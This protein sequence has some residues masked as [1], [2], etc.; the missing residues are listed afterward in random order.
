[1]SDDEKLA[2]P[3]FEMMQSG[4]VFG[5]AATQFD[6]L[7]TRLI[8]APLDYQTIVIGEDA[9]AAAAAKLATAAATPYIMTP[10]QLKSFSRCGSVA[11]AALR[12]VARA[13]FRNAAAPAPA[14]LNP[15]RWSIVPRASGAAATLA[16]EL[17]T[18]SEYHAVLKSLNRDAARWQLVPAHEM[19]P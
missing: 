8:A 16:P 3:S 7:P 9:P 10:E 4:C 13:R 5:S 2:A 6:E 17:R 11:R 15:K 1:M 19:E 18:W 12:R 14:A